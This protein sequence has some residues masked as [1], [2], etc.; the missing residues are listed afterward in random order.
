MVGLGARLESVMSLLAVCHSYCL[1]I[2]A[3]SNPGVISQ[4]NVAL[5]ASV[6]TVHWLLSMQ[7]PHSV[8][9]CSSPDSAALR[10]A[11]R[12]RQVLVYSSTKMNPHL[13]SI[14]SSHCQ[15]MTELSLGITTYLPA[16]SV[17]LYF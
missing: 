15:Q 14:I 4:R 9:S 2:I 13:E 8:H 10:Y 17:L 3:F 7:V 5:V 1:R 11:T 12:Q 16:Y 6:Q